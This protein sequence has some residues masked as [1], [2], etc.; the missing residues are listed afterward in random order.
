MKMSARWYSILASELA[1]RPPARLSRWRKRLGET[2]VHGPTAVQE[3]LIVAAIPSSVRHL[4]GSRAIRKASAC[5]ASAP[6][7]LRRS[8]SVG[9]GLRAR[10]LE[11]RGFGLLR[12]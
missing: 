11:S 1:P 12:W 3:E 4:S 5:G 8:D 2:R 7:V 9:H 10:D 6:G